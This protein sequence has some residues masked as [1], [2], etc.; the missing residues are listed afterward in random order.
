MITA[1]IIIFICIL[2]AASIVI[3]VPVW[4][5]QADIQTY[6]GRQKFYRLGYQ[7]LILER[8]RVKE[9]RRGFYSDSDYHQIPLESADRPQNTEKTAVHGPLE[10]VN[11][12][13]GFGGRSFFTPD[14][15][16]D[17]L[18]LYGI[19]DGKMH[20]VF[21]YPCYKENLDSLKAF[22]VQHNSHGPVA[23]TPLNT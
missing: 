18:R 23:F 7:R 10:I 1:A 15:P 9:Y 6:S 11:R 20:L 3:H 22:V 19:K 17:E 4:K 8:Y 5:W 16:F 21:K 2:L 13:R 12:M 14:L